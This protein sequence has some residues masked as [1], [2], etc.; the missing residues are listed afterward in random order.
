M[1][2]ED[3]VGGNFQQQYL[4]KMLTKFTSALSFSKSFDMFDQIAF[5]NILSMIQIS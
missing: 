1:K 4:F 2:K 3:I 5:D